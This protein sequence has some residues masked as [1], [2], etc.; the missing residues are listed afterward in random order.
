[1]AASVRCFRHLLGQLVMS[2][3]TLEAQASAAAAGVLHGRMNAVAAVAAQLRGLSTLQQETTAAENTRA[4]RT[5]SQASLI[6]PSKYTPGALKQA[7]HVGYTVM[8][9]F[10]GSH[11]WIKRQQAFA[12]VQVG[13]HQFKV[14]PGD[15]IY[16]EKLK[17]T[18]INDKL[19]L[20]KV[21]LVG[22]T[23]K[24]IVGRPTV[25]DTT[26]YAA[27]EEH[28]LDAKVIIFKKKRRKNYRRCNGHRQE[29]TALRILQIDGIDDVSDVLVRAA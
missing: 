24:T 27:V 17:Y 19:A 11:I 5:E 15:L 14:T 23:S 12:V 20:A 22:T 1:M 28:A 10:D 18:D 4:T 7:A 16:T 9:R 29:L 21:L 25:P 8:G 2:P 13:S 26:V 6:A 3:E